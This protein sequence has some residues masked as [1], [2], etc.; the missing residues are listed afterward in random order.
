MMRMRRR[1]RSS[2]SSKIGI[3]LLHVSASIGT[4]FLILQVKD[5]R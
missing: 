5:K 2:S 3:L 1:R 4:F